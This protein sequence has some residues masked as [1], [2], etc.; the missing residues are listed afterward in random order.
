MAVSDVCNRLI[1]ISTDVDASR[2][3]VYLMQSHCQV[4]LFKQ[5]NSC[6]VNRLIKIVSTRTNWVVIVY[7][8]SVCTS[9]PTSVNLNSGGHQAIR[10]CFEITSM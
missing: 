3:V 2:T 6:L 9:N 7:G 1:N 8:R 5:F 10:L 4:L